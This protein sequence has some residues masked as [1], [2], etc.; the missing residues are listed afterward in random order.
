MAKPDNLKGRVFYDLT[1][2]E[3]TD[4]KDNGYAVWLCRCKCGNTIY[5]SSRQLKRGTVRGCADCWSYGR[6]L[7]KDLSGRIFG[8]LKVLHLA[9][10]RKY[11]RRSWVCECSCGK[12]CVQTSHDL[13]R[14][15]VVTCGDGIHKKRK[16][17]V[18]LTNRKIGFLNVL[19]PLDDRD[20]KG[21]VFWRC[22]CTRCGKECS[23]TADILLRGKTISCG[24]Y[25]KEELG[26]NLSDGLHHI[27][28]TCVEF[29]QRKKR[30]DNTTGYTGVYQTANGRWRAGITFKKKRYYLGTY[31]NLEDALNARRRGEEMHRDFLDQFYEQHP[32]LK[33]KTNESKLN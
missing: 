29:L 19:F 3:L 11:G 15:H 1:V 33:K 13:L 23:Y 32:E 26:K 18:D 7:P 14:G 2:E 21:S 20:S 5:A 17:F 25:R 24:C 31:D 6:N 12:I 10:E 4:Q 8:G 22:L 28:G 30:K 9:D 16:G 27:D